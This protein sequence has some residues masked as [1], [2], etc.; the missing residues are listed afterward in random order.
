MEKLGKENFNNKIE[1]SK[2]VSPLEGGYFLEEHYGKDNLIEEY[3]IRDENGKIVEFSD[4]KGDKNLYERIK[5]IFKEKGMVLKD[6]EVKKITPYYIK[7]NQKDALTDINQQK[8]IE[9]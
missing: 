2:K 8:D 1:F 4:I 9:N 3:F 5:E 7:E 6:E